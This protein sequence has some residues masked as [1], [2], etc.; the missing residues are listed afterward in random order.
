MFILMI[1]YTPNIIIDVRICKA[2]AVFEG[3]SRGG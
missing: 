2:L 1:L 3:M